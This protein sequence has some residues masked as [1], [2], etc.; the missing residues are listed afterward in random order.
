[1]QVLNALWG[2]NSSS[3]TQAAAAR[4]QV[5]GDGVP[6]SSTTTASTQ[7][8]SGLVAGRLGLAFSCAAAVPEWVSFHRVSSAPFP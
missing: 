7:R 2:C 1:M 5:G 3:G 4:V 6:T 8:G